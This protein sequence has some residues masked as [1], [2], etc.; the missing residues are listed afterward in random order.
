MKLD[1]AKIRFERSIENI[2]HLKEQGAVG[3][4]NCLD[5]R[6]DAFKAALAT[7]NQIQEIQ[8]IADK[9]DDSEQEIDDM[10]ECSAQLL[11][12]MNKYKEI[13]NE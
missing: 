10:A 7:I 6:C 12:T 2:Q 4:S 11:T 1:E 13:Y 3:S 8:K 9:F 5:D